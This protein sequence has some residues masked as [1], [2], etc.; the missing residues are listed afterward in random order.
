[1]KCATDSADSYPLGLLL[2][3][4]DSRVVR[5]GIMNTF[6]FPLGIKDDLNLSQKR[7]AEL[8]DIPWIAGKTSRQSHYAKYLELIRSVER[9]EQLAGF[10]TRL[11][12]YVSKSP[13][14]KNIVICGYIAQSMYLYSFNQE[15]PAYNVLISLNTTSKRNLKLLFVNHP[16]EKNKVWD[17]DRM[18]LDN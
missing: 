1:V 14:L 17:F 4:A 15:I 2:K 18:K 10:K 5:Y 16:S 8:K 9:M 3:N 13:N 7:V 12:D 6:R 11:I